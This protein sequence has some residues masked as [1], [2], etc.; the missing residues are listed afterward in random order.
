MTDLARDYLATGALPELPADHFIA[1]RWAAPA[2]GQRMET[3]DP[4]LARPFHAV[5]AGTAEDV[6][7]AVTAAH[8]AQNAWGRT[9][10]SARGAVLM[11]AAGG[12]Q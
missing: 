6:D 9:K 5:A 3:F 11:R 4:G 10:A 7:R 1:G 12:P 2:A 8:A